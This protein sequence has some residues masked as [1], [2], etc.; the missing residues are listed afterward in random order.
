MPTVMITGASRGIGREFARQYAE[1]G[2]R[3]VAACRDPAAAGRDGAHALGVTDDAAVAALAAELEGE[4]IDVLL[5]NAG[6]FGP[7]GLAFGALD[8]AAWEEV[9]R[10][11]AIAPIRVAQAFADHVARS[12]R[13]LMVFVSSI[14][15]SIAEGAG[16][17]Y[18]MYGAS[19]AAL[20]AAMKGISEDL[21]TRGVTCVS[22]HPGWVRTDMGGPNAAIDTATSV[23]GLRE[24]IERLRPEDNGRFY[25]YTGRELPW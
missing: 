2:W 14:L 9:L 18:V 19:K 15:G 17:E 6:V 12:E 1:A 13:R 3:V 25:D 4:A 22:V 24:V 20:N 5:N 16:G 23:A 8:F 10:V 7:R 21:A 11:N